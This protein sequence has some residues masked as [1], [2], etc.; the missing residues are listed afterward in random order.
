MQDANLWINIH[1]TWQY[2]NIHGY[3]LHEISEMWHRHRSIGW[4][5][6]ALSAWGMDLFVLGSAKGLRA[7]IW[8]HYKKPIFSMCFDFQYLSM[9]AALN[10]PSVFRYA[11]SQHRFAST[12]ENTHRMAVGLAIRK[13]TTLKQHHPGV[14][15]YLQLI[16]AFSR[17]HSTLQTQARNPPETRWQAA[18]VSID[19]TS[20]MGDFQWVF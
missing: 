17:P 18:V 1:N 9:L 7:V 13:K 15:T 11:V 3:M 4:K 16:V 12:C 14:K 6:T 5:I 8:L 2:A 20:F 10:F 19:L